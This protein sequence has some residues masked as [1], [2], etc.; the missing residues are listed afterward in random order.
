L[1][2]Y[3]ILFC[4]LA[5]GLASINVAEAQPVTEMT[6]QVHVN[7]LLVWIEYSYDTTNISCVTL[8]FTISPLYYEPYQYMPNLFIEFAMFEIMD[9]SSP[10]NSEYSYSFNLTSERPLYSPNQMST[11]LTVFPKVQESP[12]HYIRVYGTFK[13][14]HLES[15]QWTIANIPFTLRFSL[16][17]R[18]NW[19]AL[20][21]DNNSLETSLNSSTNMAYTFA[22]ATLILLAT[23]A[24]FGLEWRRYRKILKSIR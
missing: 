21:T 24:F 10:L 16:Y 20:K 8:K 1:K 2:S 13:F 17:D 15:S 7:D 18:F 11:T 4:V 3:I 22:A 23:T 14:R 12:P 6:E 19:L 9:I 5:I